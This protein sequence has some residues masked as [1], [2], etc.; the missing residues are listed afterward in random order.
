MAADAGQRQDRATAPCH[1]ACLQT[2]R[3]DDR[4][5]PGSPAVLAYDGRFILQVVGWV[6]SSFDTMSMVLKPMP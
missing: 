3:G 2:T 5:D 4:Q 6:T 1:R